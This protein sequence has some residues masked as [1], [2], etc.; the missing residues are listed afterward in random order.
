MGEDPASRVFVTNAGSPH[1]GPLPEGEG[2]RLC[3]PHPNLQNSK[4]QLEDATHAVAEDHLALAL[5]AATV[6]ID[7]SAGTAEQRLGGQPRWRR[8]SRPGH[9]Q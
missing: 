1:P 2:D 6:W 8:A 9:R 7:V 3:G 5:V 4:L